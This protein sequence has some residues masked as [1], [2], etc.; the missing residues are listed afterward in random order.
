MKIHLPNTY[1]CLLVDCPVT[2]WSTHMFC[3]LL[4]APAY[5]LFPTALLVINLRLLPFHFC[6]LAILQSTFLSKRCRLWQQDFRNHGR[7]YPTT[8]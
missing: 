1:F 8:S 2:P 6:F 4:C 7:R 5:V 3:R